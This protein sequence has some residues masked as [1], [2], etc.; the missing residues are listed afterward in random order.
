MGEVVYLV[1]AAGHPN[2]GDEA[3]VVGWLRFL[4]GV[5][6]EAAV[7][8]DCPNPV[9][10]RVLFEDM[11]PHLLVTDALWRASARSPR[12][13]A[14]GVWA[15]VESLVLSGTDADFEP[16]T[17][18]GS[19]HLLGGG[20]INAIWPHQ[21]GVV[22]G[23]AAA[24]HLSGAALYG[25]GLGLLPECQDLPRLAAVLQSFDHISCRDRPS[26][27]RFGL[28][29]GVDDLFLGITTDSPPLRG[30]EHRARDVMV[31][32]QQ[33]L[34]HPESFDLAAGLLRQRI[35]NDL[36]EGKTIGYVEAL[37][38]SDRR[39]FEALEGLVAEA[40]LIP[41]AELWSDGLPAR[42]GQ[43]WYTSRFHLHLAAAARGA[44]GTALGIAPG[45]YDIKHRSLQELGTGWRYAG[46]ESLRDL[47]YPTADTSFPDR[48]HRYAAAKQGEAITLYPPSTSPGPY[49]NRGTGRSGSLPA[50]RAGI[51]VE[52]NVRTIDAR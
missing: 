12:R 13:D 49:A 3:I 14:A 2:F 30:T 15:F 9:S 33:D 5:R 50:D 35:K 4:A 25:T 1:S 47:P 10:A 7:V 19:I 52:T 20:Y 48:C 11:H 51:L 45:Y 23:V 37:P 36:A 34:M 40:D 17:R 22:A 38:G 21:S 42:P 43:Q 16:L 6:P 41:F 26:A 44:A 18:A 32:V 8:L 29:A 39:M 28:P 46:L 24:G 31:C 27:H